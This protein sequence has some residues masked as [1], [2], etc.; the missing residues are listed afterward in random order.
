MSKVKLVPRHNWSVSSLGFD[1]FENKNNYQN[2]RFS[3][4]LSAENPQLNLTAPWTECGMK[5]CNW[6]QRE[7]LRDQYLS[8]HSGFS[9]HR[10]AN[11]KRLISP[12]IFMFCKWVQAEYLVFIQ[13]PRGIL[14]TFNLISCI[15]RIEG[16]Y[17]PLWGLGFCERLCLYLKIRPVGEIFLLCHRTWSM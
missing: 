7:H 16:L 13:S 11:K 1:K 2:Y 12:R 5:S 9:P 8:L 17:D 15:R 6:L 4:S 10:A 3:G 14:L